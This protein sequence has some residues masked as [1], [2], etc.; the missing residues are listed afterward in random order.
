MECADFARVLL[1][2]TETLTLEL[3]AHA[4]PRALVPRKAKPLA[5]YEFRLWPPNLSQIGVMFHPLERKGATVC[6]LHMSETDYRVID[7]GAYAP[8][9]TEQPKFWDADLLLD[10]PKD[11]IYV[12]GET[13]DWILLRRSK[14]GNSSR[15]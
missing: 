8:A 12:V 15:G 14:S 6:S 9:L 4:P 5:M 10:A 2:T 13:G 3:R 7:W 11:S 1:Q